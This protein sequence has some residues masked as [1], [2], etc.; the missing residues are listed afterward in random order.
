[1]RPLP[2]LQG[3][4]V[5]AAT[6]GRACAADLLPD[7][8]ELVA[9]LTSPQ[10]AVRWNG[11]YA[12]VNYGWGTEHDGRLPFCVNP[13]GLRNGVGCVENNVP[14]GGVIHEN[15]AAGGQIGY[16]IQFDHFVLGGETDFQFSNVSGGVWLFGD[17][18]FPVTG[19]GTSRGEFE[20]DERHSWF[21]TLRARTG[22]VVWDRVLIYATAGLAYAHVTADAYFWFP[23]GSSVAGTG[24]STKFGPAA[25]AGVE[26]KLN[27]NW[28]VR[29]EFL[30][31]DLGA[32]TVGSRVSPA[33]GGFGGGKTFGTELDI[34]RAGVNY[35]VF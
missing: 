29:A 11:F 28:S 14:T 7:P 4:I 32:V 18:P 17:R 19:G 24:E 31:Y 6:I 16:N 12:G 15:Y 1:M 5:L 27:K 34:F 26:Y 30:W 22:W 8:G 33:S 9:T 21:G 10:P 2:L 35:Q 13:A 23:N 20:F 25:A 3:G